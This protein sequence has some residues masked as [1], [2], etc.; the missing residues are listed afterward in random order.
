MMTEACESAGFFYLVNHGIEESV[1]HA[2]RD[3][4]LDFFRAPSD[5]KNQY[6]ISRYPHHRGYVG[7]HDVYPDPRNRGDIRQA[8]KVAL[9]LPDDDPDYLAGVTMYGPNVW[10]DGMPRF[11]QHVYHAYG[12]FQKL[13]RTIFGLFA[14]GLDLPEDYFVHLTDKPASVM[15]LNYYAG[16]SADHPDKTSGI[17]AHNDYEA[18]AMLWQDGVGGLQIESPGGSWEAVVPLEE[19][20]VINIGELMQRWT[21]DRFRATRH[22]VINTSERERFSMACFGNTNYHARIECIPSCCSRENPAR[23]DSVMSGEYLMDAVR[24]TY[25]YTA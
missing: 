20:L 7:N 12:N 21:N 1:F 2:A 14:V 4:A 25:A 3:A 17:G 22:R 16:R 18:F 23:Y 10:P 13:A 8:F 9:E 11:R 24:R 15:N 5:F 19:A 6:H